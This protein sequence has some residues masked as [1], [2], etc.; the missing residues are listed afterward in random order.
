MKRF[1]IV[2][3]TLLKLET[4]T[5]YDK[6]RRKVIWYALGWIVTVI[7]ITYCSTLKLK[8]ENDGN[9]ASIIYFSFLRDYCF[10]INL[11]GDLINA[12]I[13]ELVH[14]FTYVCNY[15]FILW[16]IVIHVNIHGIFVIHTHNYSCKYTFHKY[17]SILEDKSIH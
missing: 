2:D 15:M 3:N 7:L 9:I 1:D 17:V 4:M 6:L 13:L 12:S 8:E 5:D 16:H 14:L 11:M 10:H